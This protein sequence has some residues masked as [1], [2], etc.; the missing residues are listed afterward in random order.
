MQKIALAQV[1]A[2]ASSHHRRG[3]RQIEEAAHHHHHRNLNERATQQVLHINTIVAHKRARE[4]SSFE[5]PLAEMTQH[6]QTPAKSAAD[7]DDETEDNSG[8]LQSADCQV[9]SLER[10]RG[11]CL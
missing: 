9:D 10:A 6:D 5:W 2:P 4:W 11:S 8:R 7:D 1:A 3:Q